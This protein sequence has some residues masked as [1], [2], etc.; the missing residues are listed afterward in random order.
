MNSLDQRIHTACEELDEFARARRPS[1]EQQLQLETTLFKAC[2]NPKA[3]RC[4]ALAK[5]NY[6]RN[7]YDFTLESLIVTLISTFPLE[8]QFYL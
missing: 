1:L 7:H 6:G 8:I 5:L 3:S 2:S 4:F